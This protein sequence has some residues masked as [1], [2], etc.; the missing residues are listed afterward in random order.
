MESALHAAARALG[1][2]PRRVRELRGGDINRAHA[3]ELADGRWVFVKSNPQ[4][5]EGL[6]A[7]EARGLAWLGEPGALRV[8]TVL[9]VSGSDAAQ[10]AARPPF[11]ALELIE[12]AKRVGDFDERLGRGLA[13]LHRASLP[14][15]G[16]DHDNFIGTM[17]QAN[18]AASDWPGFLAQRRLLP[19]LGRAVDAGLMPG[20]LRRRLERVVQRLPQL[21]GPAEPPARL[22]GDLWGGNLHVDEAGLPVLI[23]PAAYAGHREMDLA[24]MRLFG[25][26]GETVFAAY[27]ESWPLS[28]GA[29]DRVPLY[30]LYPLLVHV[31]HFGAGYLSALASTLAPID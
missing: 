28:E 31:N 24:M 27:R 2:E 9:A 8:P 30:Q 4:A 12:P 25:G 23:D 10:H 21:C 29:E 26:F 16:L 13:A 22:H 20:E 15:F 5:P 18:A 7:A 11:L 1:S 17:S 6:F 14:R 19:Q 3:V